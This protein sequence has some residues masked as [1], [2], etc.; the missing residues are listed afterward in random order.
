MKVNRYNNGGL[1]LV[2]LLVV[3]A[4]IA[5]LAA[6]LLAALLQAKKRPYYA[7][8][9]NNLKQVNVAVHLYAGDNEDKAPNAGS[10]TY[11][12]YKEVVK[13]YAGLHGPS[14]VA[15]KVFGCPADTFYYDETS[16]AYS[17][18]GLRT[19]RSHDFTSYT[20]NGLN[21]LTNYPN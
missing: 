11:I 16:L 13:G 6:L 17:P 1:T 19:Q 18:N 20:F 9:L 12:L 21:L 5:I 15:D 2:E 8:C 4:I 7:T 14:S 10:A 3:I